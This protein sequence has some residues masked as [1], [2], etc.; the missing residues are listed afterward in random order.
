MILA[1][2]VAASPTRVLESPIMSPFAS[3]RMP[4][5]ATILWAAAF[6]LWASGCAH[7][8]PVTP[9][10][11]P[12]RPHPGYERRVDELTSVDASGLSGR[13]I[14]ID[15]GHGGMF[16]G[17][18]G[19]H[20]LTEAE[21]NL[22]VAL[23]LDSLLESK[24]AI[25]FMTR[26]TD[27]DF[28]SPADSSLKFDLTQRVA[29]ANAFQPDLFLSIHH[30]ADARGAHD[31]NETQTYYK[32]GDDG[33]SLDA[34]SDVHRYLVRNLG[35]ERQRILPGN[36]FVLRSCDA[37]AL[38]TESSY[39]TNPDVE[40]KL[41]LAEKRRLEAEALYLGLAHYFAR[42]VPVIAEFRAPTPWGGGLEL[43]DTIPNSY[44]ALRARIEG[45][46]DRY[47]MR[48]DGAL[49]EPMR[50]GEA[51]AW[52][53]VTPLQ[54]G[55]HEATLQVGLAGEGTSRESRVHFVVA[56]PP[57]ELR[58]EFPGQY[59]WDGTQPLALRIRV[60]N[61]DGYPY[62]D[63]YYTDTFKI[64]IRM[65]PVG[66]VAPADTVIAAHEGTAWL[67]VRALRRP[68]GT[69]GV[70]VRALVRPTDD[71]LGIEEEAIA[72]IGAFSGQ[73]R[74]DERT[75]FARL[76]PTGDTLRQVRGTEGF[77]PSLTWINRDGFVC[78]NRDSTGKV[79]VPQLRGYR[80]WVTGHEAILA[81][82]DS[83]EAREFVPVPAVSEEWP[84]RFVAI[85]GGA[86]H[87]HRITLDPAGGGDEAAGTGVSGTRAS[88]L[89]LGVA[90]A[91]AGFLTAAGAEVRLTRAG[92]YALS[93]VERVQISE[94]FHAER[95]LRIG[96][97]PEPPMI[98]HYFSSPAG[99]AWAQRTA[100]AFTALAIS[101]PPIAEDAQ[102][103]LQQTSC[104]A[105]YVSPA[106]VD[107]AAREDHLLSP[108]VLR[109]EAYALFIALARE[110]SDGSVWPA[111][112]IVV[113]DAAGQP[114][115]GVPI[116]L[117]GAITIVTDR[118]GVARFARTEPGPIEVET[119]LNGTRERR[120]LLELERGLLLST[121]STGR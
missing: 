90:R 80:P 79:S 67:Y 81:P 44:P 11:T 23:E 91:L 57:H 99:L 26:K 119:T 116:S 70:V 49:I 54:S 96:H 77:E 110:W 6:A 107:V 62:V 120:I 58:P 121:G 29:L 43:R 12:T 59:T 51:L 30:N 39:L 55:D 106:R 27:R 93:D 111:D 85:C 1:T 98:G 22:G 117:G 87:G 68:K 73:A 82:R 108:G 19:V 9:V 34:A 40:A 78:L 64:H 8:P 56:D 41:T 100:A 50:H 84:P 97:A 65:R 104:P 14:V 16:R 94:D 105:L 37:P 118:S 95:F 35:I 72:K 74:Q 66:L 33:P 76:M 46:F 32:L 88:S 101:A 115:A 60:F 18:I 63:G 7:N 38:L 109:A 21:V 5:R 17:A 53:P 61:L 112:S 89:N 48:L 15:P 28:V 75:G 31:V 71:E 102:Y 92:D 25:V 86:L 2:N 36:Y 20:G 24:G 4:R 69:K 45:P 113:R 103:P 47:E 42:R 13:R 114:L 52:V 3:A 10:T 83:A